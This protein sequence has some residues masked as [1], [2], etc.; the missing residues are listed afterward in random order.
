MTNNLSLTF[1]TWSG[2]VIADASGAQKLKKI[3]NPWTERPPSVQTLG[4]G[5]GTYAAAR[6]GEGYTFASA[7]FFRRETL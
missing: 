4:E 3:G 2:S 5:E 7:T 1:I 6:L